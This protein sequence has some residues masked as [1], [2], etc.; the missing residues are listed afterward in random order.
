MAIYS[1]FTVYKLNL[2]SFKLSLGCLKV[3]LLSKIII[4]FELKSNSVY[5]ISGINVDNE[6]LKNNYWKGA[7]LQKQSSRTIE[8]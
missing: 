4:F 7:E 5:E 3:S 8:R 2:G 1:Y 6:K